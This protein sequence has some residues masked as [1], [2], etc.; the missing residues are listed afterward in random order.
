MSN[1]YQG[2]LTAV[3]GVVQAPREKGLV[4]SRRVASGLVV[5]ILGVISMLAG[6]LAV[7]GTAAAT[8]MGRPER[9]GRASL[10]D[11]F[12]EIAVV[13]H[14]PAFNVLS[15]G[16]VVPDGGGQDEDALQDVDGDAG[17]RLPSPTR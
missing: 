11:L 1:F 15:I 12:Q 9:P 4:V 10:D 3:P 6:T 5:A 8:S 17:W 7:S 16:F 14:E 2:G 13:G